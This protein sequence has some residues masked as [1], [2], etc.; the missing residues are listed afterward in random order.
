MPGKG[1]IEFDVLC[2]TD[3]IENLCTVQVTASKAGTDF[4]KSFDFAPG[5][6]STDLAGYWA[7]AL[8]DAGFTAT[9]NGSQVKL[10]GITK[11]DGGASKGRQ[12][13]IT[14]TGETGVT[15][16]EPRN[17]PDPKS[18]KVTRASSPGDGVLVVY[19]ASIRF[20]AGTLPTFATIRVAEASV[21]YSSGDTAAQII[22]R[23]QG[24]LDD[25]GWTS[26]IID[27]SEIEITKDPEELDI[28]SLS[29]TTFPLPWSGSDEE[30]PNDDHWAVLI[31][32]PE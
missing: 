8:A 32:E 28:L 19:A 25:E 29:L 5:T 16:E 22:T 11:L 1:T 3:E 31:K 10:D 7:K 20:S 23:L 26:E 15:V 17:L 24:V 6:T 30:T 21:T 2:S 4:D 18:I 27:G 14:L 9:A 13:K 12:V